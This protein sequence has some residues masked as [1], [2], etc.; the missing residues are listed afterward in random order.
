MDENE[1]H[2]TL[3]SALSQGRKGA[4]SQWKKRLANSVLCCCAA[5]MAVTGMAG[6]KE[7]KDRPRGEGGLWFYN[8]M[9]C[10]ITRSFARR[11]PRWPRR[12]DIVFGLV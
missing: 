6:E 1:V 5:V 2:K 12:R 8:S 11:A 9:G 7:K 10:P 3:P 4:G